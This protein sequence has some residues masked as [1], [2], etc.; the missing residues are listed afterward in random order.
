MTASNTIPNDFQKKCL[1]LITNLVEVSGSS[2]FLVDPD[3]QHRGVVVSNT[4]PDIDREYTKNYAVMDPLNPEKFANSNI[5][6]ATIDSQIPPNLLKQTIFYQDFMVPFNVRYI[7][8]IFF[9]D[10]ERIIAVL[11]LLRNETLSDFSKNELAL[12]EK[13]QPFIE[14]SLNT[15]YL[16]K[17]YKERRSIKDKYGFTDREIDVLEMLLAGMSNK[18]IATEINL[19]LATI[20]THL[21]HIFQ[22]AS[23]E[24]RSELVAQILIDLKD[25]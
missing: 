19:G 7:A 12:L 24:S 15:I 4:D 23:T 6:V 14:Y 21:H 3:M 16:P 11:S 18:Q 2:F 5:R 25:S 8:D 10:S 1:E 13:V 20:K 22:K 17:K 9:R